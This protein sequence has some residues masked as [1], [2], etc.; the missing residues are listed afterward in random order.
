MSRKI[1]PSKNKF[2]PPFIENFRDLNRYHLAHKIY[3]TYYNVHV[4]KFNDCQ[5]NKEYLE[6]LFDRALE[7]FDKF[8]L[9]YLKQFNDTTIKNIG[10]ENYVE[11]FEYYG[12]KN[13]ILSAKGIIKLFRDLNM[14]TNLINDDYSLTFNEF[15]DFMDNKCVNWKKN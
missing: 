7:E 2:T 12:G 11:I 6:R 13:N 1:I 8:E 5:E 4:F 14:N 15:I 10:D 9:E 3:E